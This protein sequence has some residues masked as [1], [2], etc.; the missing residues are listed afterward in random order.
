VIVADASA[1]VELLLGGAR[2]RRVEEILLEEDDRIQAPALLDGEVTQALRRLVVAGV[3]HEARGRVAVEILGELPITRHLL[4]PLLPRMWQLRG[5]LTAYDAA[6]VSLAEALDCPLL[7]YDEGI[8]GAP[9]H[10]ARILVPK[11]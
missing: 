4:T 5:A 11:R 1:V 3:M 2:G 10:T 6:Y 9:G 7:T 8:V